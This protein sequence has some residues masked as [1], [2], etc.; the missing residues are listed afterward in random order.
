MVELLTAKTFFLDA[1]VDLTPTGRTRAGVKARAEAIVKI[2][3]E[4]K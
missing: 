3:D 4:T 1:T 2:K